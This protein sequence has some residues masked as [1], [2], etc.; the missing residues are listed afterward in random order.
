MALSEEATTVKRLTEA[1]HVAAVRGEW[2]IVEACYRQREAVLRDSALP[3]EVVVRIQAL[4]REVAERARLAQVGV[5][6]SLHDAAL[7]RRRLEELRRRIN[8]PVGQS[9][10]I[11]KRG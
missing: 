2:N 5:A 3:D 1:A 9:S 7:W 10:T 8:V 4:D 11:V 6:A